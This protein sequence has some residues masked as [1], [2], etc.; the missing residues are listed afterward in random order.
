MIKQ[1]S[2]MVIG[3][4]NLD[5]TGKAISSSSMAAQSHI[6]QITK[7]SGGVARNIAESLGRLGQSVRLLSA[8]GDD[9]DSRAMQDE[10]SSAGVIH[11]LSV[12]TPHQK[13]DSYLA[14]YDEAGG[15]ISAINDMPLIETIN[16]DIINQYQSQIKD[17]DRVVIDANLSPD[18]LNAICALIGNHLLAADAVSIKKAA[19]LKPYLSSLGLLKVTFE[20]AC[21]LVDKSE[22]LSL[23]QILDNLHEQGVQMILLSQSAAGFTLSSGTDRLSKSA[24]T[25]IDI[26][27][28]AGAG[29]GLF[30]GTLYGLSQGY[31]FGII[32]DIAHNMA[33][34][35][36][37]S[38]K[39]VNPDLTSQQIDP[40][41]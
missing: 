11:N 36:L 16:S 37:A 4:A 23:D 9:E 10:L 6:G 1:A 14:I 24:N 30:A 28:S 33:K 2:F 22:T 35:A 3:G 5:I 34:S 32:A 40:L 19:K 31:E 12:I 20:E 7:S 17:A 18:T 27:N 26:I 13:A 29:D 41:L 8:F 21:Q 25:D 15:L 38:S 39:A